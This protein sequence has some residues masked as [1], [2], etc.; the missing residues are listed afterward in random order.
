[1]APTVEA[2][3]EA[4]EVEAVEVEAASVTAPVEM[5]EGVEAQVREAPEWDLEE[6]EVP[7]GC[8]FCMKRIFPP[9]TFRTGKLA[10][11]SDG[12][13]PPHCPGS[14]SLQELESVRTVL[15]GMRA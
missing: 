4:A 5:D 13:S 3:P 11:Y 12:Y 9:C 1:M 10:R 7:R 2:D 8:G 6:P 15:G 14:Y